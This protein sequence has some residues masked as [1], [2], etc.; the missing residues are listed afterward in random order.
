MAMRG[1]AVVRRPWRVEVEDVGEPA[2]EA[3]DSTSSM[4]L[5]CQPLLTLTIA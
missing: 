3:R 4:V 2:A 1:E 5:L